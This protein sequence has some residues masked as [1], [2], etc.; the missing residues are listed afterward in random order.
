MSKEKPQAAE[1]ATMHS[2]DLKVI[3][4]IGPGIENRLHKAGIRSYTQLA[5]LSPKEVVSALG[6]MIGMTE[7]R[8]IDQDWIGQARSLEAESEPVLVE[9]VEKDSNSISRKHYATFTV[10][11]LLDDENQV[12]RTRTTHFQSDADETWAGWEQERLVRFFID[13]AALKIPTPQAIPVDVPVVAP[14]PAPAMLR[15]AGEPKLVE[16]SAVPDGENRPQHVIPSSQFFGV[17]ITLDMSGI[18]APLENPLSYHLRLNSH[19]LKSQT[20]QTMRELNGSFPLADRETIH[21]DKLN[22]EEGIYRLEASVTIGSTTGEDQPIMAF[23]EGNLL[24]VY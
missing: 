20:R 21:L 6:T 1:N 3:H 23:L 24:R 17:T 4:G 8:V 2:D 16:F 14:E 18:T 22:L 10:E 7:E 19:N 13:R 5:G 9:S 12:R 11:L 15:L